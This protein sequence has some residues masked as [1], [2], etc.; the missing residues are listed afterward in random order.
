MIS[1][2]LSRKQTT[3]PSRW[4][5]HKLMDY[6]PTEAWSTI[7][8]RVVINASSGATDSP[9]VATDGGTDTDSS[10]NMEP[11]LKIIDIN[12]D[13]ASDDRENLNDEYII[14]ENTGD[15]SLDLADWTVQ[16]ESGATYA[17]PDGSV[18]DSDETVTLRTGSGDDTQRSAI[19]DQSV[20]SGTTLEIQ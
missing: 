5:R 20:R 6:R 16:D 15:T 12:A 14:F 10:D 4:E 11:A 8:K 18:L 17:F 3:S 9:A 2:Q 13:A 19:G 7:T 1:G